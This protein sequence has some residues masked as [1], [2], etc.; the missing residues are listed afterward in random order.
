[1]Q[2]VTYLAH[3]CSQTISDIS[4][5]SPW[6][7]THGHRHS[8]TSSAKHIYDLSSYHIIGFRSSVVARMSTEEVTHEIWQTRSCGR[9]DSTDY[10]SRGCFVCFRLRPRL[11]RSFIHH[12]ESRLHR[13]PLYDFGPLID[14]REVDEGQAYI[15]RY[16]IQSHRDP[17]RRTVR[18]C[19]PRPS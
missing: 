4:P 2:M 7:Q 3:S 9:H 17:G 14:K 6:S 13:S 19:A 11:K 8:L 16:G 18:E 10:P 15:E 1:M 5:P 12:P